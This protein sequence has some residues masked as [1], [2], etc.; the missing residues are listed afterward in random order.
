MLKA[1][2]YWLHDMYL[3]NMIA[4]PVISNPGWVFPR[5][6]FESRSDMIGFAADLAAGICSF[7]QDLEK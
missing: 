6:R 5:Q 2:D 3:D 4:L 1:Y 7:K